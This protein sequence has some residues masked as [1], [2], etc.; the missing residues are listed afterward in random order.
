MLDRRLEEQITGL[1]AQLHGLLSGP[2]LSVRLEE[3]RAIAVELTRCWLAYRGGSA[4][5]RRAGGRVTTQH[6]VD[7]AYRPDEFYALLA[8]AWRASLE[9]GGR[10]EAA[11]G[12]IGVWSAPRPGGR[13]LMG[14]WHFQ[15]GPTP[16]LQRIE[17]DPGF[18]LEELLAQL[19]EL[20]RQALGYVK[21]GR[22]PPAPCSGAPPR[23][24]GE[25]GLSG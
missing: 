2:M 12:A 25:P 11:G 13:E 19:G 9:R 17:I 15:E 16:C 10:Y 23:P 21:H 7:Y 14:T 24:R 6:Y 8:A 1:L 18:G 20:E 4:P 22:A 5:I 3:I